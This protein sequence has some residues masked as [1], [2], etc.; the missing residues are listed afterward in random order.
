MHLISHDAWALGRSGL[1]FSSPGLVSAGFQYG[2]QEMVGTGALTIWSGALSLASL[3]IG[4][5]Y[6]LVSYLVW[7]SV[8]C[9][10]NGWC[11]HH[12]VWRNSGPAVWCGLPGDHLFHASIYTHRAGLCW[13]HIHSQSMPIYRHR[14]RRKEKL[15]WNRSNLGQCLIFLQLKHKNVLVQT[16]HQRTLKYS[17][18]SRL[19]C[20]RVKLILVLELEE[21]AWFPQQTYRVFSTWKVRALVASSR[22]LYVLWQ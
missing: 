1:V 9:P 12:L 16:Q 7:F 17:F 2:V 21:P 11:S 19:R 14:R 20:C 3:L 22:T 6:L 5:S 8:W 10:G 4:V 18:P 15:G 13:Q